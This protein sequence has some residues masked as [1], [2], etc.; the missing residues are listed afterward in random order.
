[1][2][3]RRA[4]L[5]RLPSSLLAAKEPSAAA[6]QPV[7]DPIVDLFHVSLPTFF[8]LAVLLSVFLYEWPSWWILSGAP[9]LVYFILLGAYNGS[10]IFPDVPVWS[11]IAGL[12]VVYSICATSWLLWRIFTFLCFPL[13]FFIGLFQFDWLSTRVRAMLR[14]VL[15]Q[16]HF[17]SDKVA[18]FNIPALEIDT[19]V[20]GLF[21]VRGLTF[22]LSNLT[23]T[24][25]GIEVGIKLSDDME[26]ALQA[27][28]VVIP[29]FRRIV[30]GD[31]Y[32]NVK[33]GQ[34]EMTFGDLAERT[35]SSKDGGA[36]MQTN[37]PL[38]QAAASAQALPITPGVKMTK[39]TD[40]MS[41]GHAPAAVSAKEGLEA[42]QVAKLSPEDEEAHE[43]YHSTLAWIASTSSIEQC[44]GKLRRQKARQSQNGTTEDLDEQDDRAGICAYLHAVPSI[45][46]PPQRSIKVTTLQNLT[47]PAIR[48]FLHRLPLLLRM[49]LNVLAYSHPIKI[50]SI[51]A[52]GSGGWLKSLLE[53]EL[54]KEYTKR[55]AELRKLEKRVAQWTEEAHFAVQLVDVTGL[56]AVPTI[57]AYDIV[58]HLEFGDVLVYRTLV[59]DMAMGKIVRLGGADAT[60]TLPTYLLPHHE[61]LLP[62]LPTKADKDTLNQEVEDAD[63]NKPKQVQ[64]EAA[65]AL[66]E[67]DSCEVQMG[68]HVCLPA[69]LD[70]ELLNFIMA[71]VKA[72]QVIEVEKQPG[73]LNGEVQGLQNLGSAMAKGVKK[74]LVEGLMDDHLI[75]K[76]LGKVTKKLETAQGDVGYSGA[77]PVALDV[78]RPKETLPSKLLP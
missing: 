56:A 11:L 21:V 76:L 60:F 23:I 67:N 74:V 8:A 39:M 54:F 15:N 51:T 28:K 57:S 34:Y 63:D 52:A 66:V 25:H 36:L 37:T 33:G 12:N 5:I 35:R 50:S 48:R 4:G 38:L 45:V 73:L 2:S 62:P 19:D 47:P 69:I 53:S 42:V 55:N 20:D 71:L 26:L 3:K 17:V 46:N 9:L 24:V 1:M 40:Y 29:L 10:R 78:Y 68:V 16:L 59:S 13:I 27:D 65:L 32:G 49:L 41:D 44:R 61:H 77:L 43:H 18:F 22:C 30:I 6:K 14:S 31:V 7:A 64:K 75:A 72:S 58:T 70:Q